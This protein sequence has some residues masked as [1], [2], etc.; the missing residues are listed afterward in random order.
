MVLETW[1]RELVDGRADFVRETAARE[2]AVR[3]STVGRAAA[4]A[5]PRTA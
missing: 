1:F 4:V 2:A 5:A 3:E